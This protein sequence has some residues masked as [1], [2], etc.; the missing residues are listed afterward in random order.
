V[1]A[2]QFIAFLERQTR[3]GNLRD[4]AFAAIHD[5]SF[6]DP[7]SWEELQTYLYGIGYQRRIIDAAEYIWRLYLAAGVERA[8]NPMEQI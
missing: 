7:R 1:S 2:N 3:R 5:S 8:F 6:P 4:F